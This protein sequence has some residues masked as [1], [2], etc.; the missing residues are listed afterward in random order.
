M[1]RGQPRK[2][3][4][5]FVLVLLA[6]CGGGGSS[7]APTDTA[8]QAAPSTLPHVVM[9]GDST[10]EGNAADGN[11]ASR[12]AMQLAGAATVV[13]EGVS[14]TTALQL[15]HGRD[16]R[17]LPWAQELELTP[18]RI[19]SVNHGLNDLE[20]LTDYR[21]ALRALTLEAQARGRIVILETPNH[22][23]NKGDVGARVQVMREVAAELRTV[24]C[25]YYAASFAEG[26]S[27]QL[28]APEYVHPNAT[29]YEHKARHF[30]RCVREALSQ[31]DQKG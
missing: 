12:A 14:G 31:Q 19:V 7:T 28:A 30:T 27:E 16:G 21:E 1:T 4:L 29:G 23:Y 26:W 11:V 15:L 9:Y 25:D 6:A 3:L 10:Q 22:A 2:S 8:Y 20:P 17:H 18:S 13:S 5:A 24:L